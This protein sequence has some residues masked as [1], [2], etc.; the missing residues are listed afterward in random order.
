VV[1]P[2][3]A[4]FAVATPP[5]MD[6][7]A[8]WRDHFAHRDPV[9]R[10][11]ARIWAS[12]GIATRHAVADPRV[13][14]LGDATTATR[15]ERYA[16][17]AGPLGVDATRRALAASDVCP[18]DVGLLATVSCTGYTTPG[19]DA[20]IAHELGMAA[21][22]R[23]VHVGHVGCHAALPTLATVAEST[24]H[25][26]VAAVVTCVELSSLHIQPPTA[27]VGQLVSHALFSDAAAA[28][29]VAPG[30]PGLAVLDLEG[31]TDHTNATAMTWT[32]TD[33]GFRLGL[34]PRV[35]AVLARHVRP[36]VDALLARH[37]LRCPDVAAWAIH[38][39]GP[40]ILEVCADKLGLDERALA[41]SYAVLRDHGNCSSATILMILAAIARAPDLGDGDPVVALAFGPGLT[42]YATLFRA[43]GPRSPST[44]ASSVTA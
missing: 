28:V 41:P 33:R 15:M 24:A 44:N 2:T 37:G 42:I 7:A 12:V 21:G 29:V 3:I 9:P 19:L 39:G 23:R 8:V 4:G 25:R 6:H 35:P 27:D 1:T 36:T 11:G 40:R 14:D 17:A 10:D 38:P 13:V 18:G 31:C 26:G 16:Q 43:A 30:G 22:L 34:S 20:Q 5:A 32:I